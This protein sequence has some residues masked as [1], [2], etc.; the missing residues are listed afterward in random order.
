MIDA[1]FTQYEKFREHLLDPDYS[2]E[3]HSEIINDVKNYVDDLVNTFDERVM[4]W[5]DMWNHIDELVILLLVR[6]RNLSPHIYAITEGQFPG[7]S[8][9]SECWDSDGFK[10]TEGY[11]WLKPKTFGTYMKWKFHG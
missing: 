11:H 3:E 8:F 4:G 7:Y 2:L 5:Q 1:E 6:L 10:D 9:V